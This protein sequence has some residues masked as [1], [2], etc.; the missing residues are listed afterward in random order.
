MGCW[1]E[2]CGLS[3]LPITPGTKSLLFLLQPGS[4]EDGRSGF[5]YPVGQ[6][7]PLT[8]PFRGEYDDDRGTLDFPKKAPLH[9]GVTKELL[10]DRKMVWREYDDDAKE[11][12]PLVAAYDY[13]TFFYPIERGWVQRSGHRGMEPVGQVLVREDVWNYLL[14]LKLDMFWGE[15]SR[16][17]VHKD[18]DRLVKYL[19]KNPPKTMS[20]AFE[21]ENHFTEKRSAFFS[22][23]FTPGESG[24]GMRRYQGML[25]RGMEEGTI[26]P[27][28]ANLVFHEIGDVAHV[29]LALS[30]LRRA[31][32]PQ[33]GKGSQDTEWKLHEGFARKVAEISLKTRK[34]EEA[35]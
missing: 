31:W 2:T 25:M 24:P 21:V 16:A 3:G 29:N 18:A 7:S 12:K 32:R 27:E 23:I 14:G 4:H 5:C 17:E 8:L 10:D 15:A 28:T 34:K 33:P 9:W 35:E 19:V 11:E 1:Y 22:T 30:G 20:E 26:K 6:W 13:E